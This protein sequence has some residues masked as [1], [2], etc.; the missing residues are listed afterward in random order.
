[1][2]PQ[3]LERMLGAIVGFRMTVTHVDAK[4]KL[5]QNRSRADRD[6]VIAG[7]DA[8]DRAVS[9]AVADWMRQ[10]ALD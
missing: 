1:M 6:G 9:A 4:F 3:L 8:R 10:Y 5:S 7:L 2:E